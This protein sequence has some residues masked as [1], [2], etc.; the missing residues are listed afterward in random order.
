MGFRSGLSLLL[1]LSIVGFEEACPYLAACGFVAK[2][3]AG[4]FGLWGMSEACPWLVGHI[5]W[6]GNGE[7]DEACAPMG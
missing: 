4:A 3:W 1:T 5:W 2:R 6:K 7:R